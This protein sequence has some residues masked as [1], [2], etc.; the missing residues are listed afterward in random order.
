MNSDVIYIIDDVQKSQLKPEKFERENDSMYKI[1]GIIDGHYII[2][3][4][5][6]LKK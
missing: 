2:K 1:V 4:P 3:T 6:E 5:K